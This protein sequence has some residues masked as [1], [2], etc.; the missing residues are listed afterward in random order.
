MNDDGITFLA[1][2]AAFIQQQAIGLDCI[3]EDVIAAGG[4]VPNNQNNLRRHFTL[5]RPVANGQPTGIP[6]LRMQV[7]NPALVPNF[8]PPSVRLPNGGVVRAIDALYLNAANSNT[9]LTQLL[10]CDIVTQP[11]PNDAHVLFTLGMNGCSLVVLSA[12]PQGVPTLAN[13]HLRVVHDRDH[14]NL[15]AWAAAGF[16]VRFAFYADAQGSGQIPAAWQ[17]APP[18]IM[19][20]NP[21][22]LP[23]GQQGLMAQVPAPRIATNF[24]FWD[25]LGWRVGSRHYFNLGGQNMRDA[26]GAAISLVPPVSTQSQPI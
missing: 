25:G 24:L 3:A 6:A 14:R 5:T 9:P 10:F 1:G 20:Y 12:V 17:A 23:W 26:E 21:H 4:Q 16:T 8:N 15:A 18:V 22:N 13:G 11:G 19:N 2:P 7:A